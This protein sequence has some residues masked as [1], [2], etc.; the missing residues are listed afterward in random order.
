MTGVQQREEPVG[1]SRGESTP[2]NSALRIVILGLSISSS[3]GN[4]HATTYRALVSQLARRGHDVLFLERD[5]PWY[6]ENRDLARL[7][8]GRLEFYAD[9]VDLRNRFSDAVRDADAVIV[10]SYVPDGVEAG[11]WVTEIARGFTVFY[12]IDTPVTLAKLR[13]GD[14]EYLS[15]DLIP[16]YQ[17]YLSFTG[18]PTLARLEKEWG[19]PRARALYCSVDPGIHRPAPQELQWDL[20]YLG[21]YSPDRQPAL[22]E[23]MLRTAAAHPRSRF[24]VAGPQYPPEIEWPSNVQRMSHLPPS[25]H[26]AFYNASRFT[27]NLTRRDMIECGYS[28]SVRLFEAAACAVPVISDWWAGL[29]EFLEPDHEIFVARTAEDV[30]R[31]LKEVSESRRI[32]VGERARQRILR[33]HTSAVRAA[34]LEQ[35]LFE[36]LQRLRLHLKEL[37]Y[38]IQ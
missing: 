1:Q 17:L 15:E 33:E 27:L 9:L 18:G 34:T 2:P 22:E 10:G 35:H 4:G 7:P 24:A 38:E 28:P 23:L 5:T 32:L 30:G 16:R 20:S 25:E 31:L 36:G 3:W 8:W 19:S 26:G 29:D 37:H 6:R 13:R 12:D 21:T 14:R 11:R